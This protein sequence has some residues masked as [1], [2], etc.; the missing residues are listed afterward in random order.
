METLTFNR[1]KYS[2][3]LMRRR[4]RAF[5]REATDEEIDRGKNWYNV[6]RQWIV[7][8]AG[9]VPIYK[10]AGIFAALSPQMPV[11]RNKKLFLQYLQTGHASHYMM[12]VDKCNA[13]MVAKTG[14]EVSRILNGNKIQAFYYNLMFP[15]RNERITIDRHA[16]SCLIQTPTKTKPIDKKTYTMTDKQYKSFERVYRDVAK[17]YSLTGNQA[18]AIL[19]ETYR[20]IRNLK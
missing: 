10:A 13:I 2:E 18:Q 15:D 14:C 3:S 12:L 5:M 7:D 16:I 20:R 6:H 9:D 4:L 8:N 19:W 11:P 17:E 1:K